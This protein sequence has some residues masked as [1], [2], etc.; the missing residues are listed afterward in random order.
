[1]CSFEPVINLTSISPE[2]AM[3]DTSFVLTVVGDN[4][5]NYMDSYCLFSSGDTSPLKKHSQI[6]GTCQV[7]AFT[8]TI[9]VSICR[10]SLDCDDSSVILTRNTALNVSSLFLFLSS[11]PCHATCL[12]RT[13]IQ[14]DS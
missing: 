5:P 1:M 10:H 11:S 7:P 9:E 3:N 4:M 13:D 14:H 6:E 12:F 8:G 2:T